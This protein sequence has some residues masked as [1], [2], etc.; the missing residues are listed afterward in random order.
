MSERRKREKKYNY[1]GASG[2]IDKI[3][4]YLFEKSLL[5]IAEDGE[6]LRSRKTPVAFIA[7][8]KYWVNNHAHVVDS[9]KIETLKFLEM[10][11]NSISLLTYITG[12]AQPK[13]NQQNLGKILTPIPP[14]LEQNRI[15]MK[16]NEIRRYL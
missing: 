3:D 7:S 13:M 10:Y 11:L 16:V 12:S 5:L 4:S 8:G 2:I 1:Y 14:L 6:N 9:L 15:I